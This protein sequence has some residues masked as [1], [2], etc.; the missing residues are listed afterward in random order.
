M[1]NANEKVIQLKHLGTAMN[2]IAAKADARFVKKEGFDDAVRTIAAEELASQLIPEN[3]KESM[4]TLTEIAAWI[5]SHPDDAS[6]MNTA[7]QA[8][9][10]KL[11]LG[12][13]NVGGETNEYDTVKEYVEAQIASIDTSIYVEKVEGKDLSTNDF[14]DEYKSKLDGLQF[15]AESEIEAMM[16]EIWNAIA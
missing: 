1:T 4:D 10:T 14:T 5:Q 13:K 11:T 2:S 9:K 3:A 15:A 7:I 6:A 16:D 8:L 12:T